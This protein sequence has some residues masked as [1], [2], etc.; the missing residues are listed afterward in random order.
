MA[1][2]PRDHAFV[3]TTK[4]E[5]AAAARIGA[6]LAARKRSELLG[7]LRSCFVR[8]EPWMQAGKYIAALASELPERNGWTIAEHIGD[9]TPGRTQ[10]LLNRAAWDT[11]AAMSQVRRFAV[12][13]LDEAARR[14]G[15]RHGLVIG[16]ID[17]TGQA[18]QG[19]ATAG[20]KRHY[21][22]CAGRVANGI[23]TV[24]LSYVRASTGHAL[25]GGRQW[26]PG[27]HIDDPVKSLVMG[28]PLDLQF[29]TKGQLA[30][31]ICTGVFADSVRFDFICGDE[32]YGNCTALREFFEMSRT[33]NSRRTN[34]ALHAQITMLLC[35]VK[36]LSGADFCGGGQA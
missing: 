1:Q 18:K 5:A 24:H 17:E 29:R 19:C 16:A 36:G 15:H 25:I 20:V 7:L 10:R 11:A 6:S 22:G 9:R 27:E 35:L 28:L 33:A 3:T 30:I 26:I 31:D 14:S 12:A 2:P 32:V 4:T 8:P 23:S 34:T 21:M 13:G